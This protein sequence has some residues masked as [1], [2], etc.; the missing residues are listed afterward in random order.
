MSENNKTTQSESDD[1]EMLEAIRAAFGEDAVSDIGDSPESKEKTLEELLAEIDAEAIDGAKTAAAANAPELADE[2]TLKYI[3]IRLGATAFGIPMDNVYEIQRVP[4][5][6]FL[7]GVPEWIQGV[8][9]LRGNVVSV[10]DLRL[11]LGL[12]INEAALS[13]QRL[14]VSQSLVDDVD[15]GFIVDQVIGIRNF[16]K[17]QIQAPTASINPQIE[18]YLTGVVDADQLIALLDVDKLLLSEE[19]RQFDAA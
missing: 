15:S 16:T 13:S 3:V 17:N 19:F 12:E 18:A 5:V 6:T 9:N 1:L 11:L 10:V 4:R 2:G 14:V 8:S 7:P